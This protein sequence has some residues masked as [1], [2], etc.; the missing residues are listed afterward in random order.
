MQLAL[1]NQML[2]GVPIAFIGGLM[3]S[4]LSSRLRGQMIA[5]L[6]LRTLVAIG[7]IISDGTQGPDDFFCRTPT[8]TQKFCM[9]AFGLQ[10]WAL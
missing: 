6:P 2:I 4:L 9:R 7:R 5:W 3:L 10:L 1:G 8:E